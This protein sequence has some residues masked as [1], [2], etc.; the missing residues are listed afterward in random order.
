M[1][2]DRWCHYIKCGMVCLV[3]V[4]SATHLRLRLTLANWRKREG[5]VQHVTVWM[6]VGPTE[7]KQEA[8]RKRN[9]DR[10]CGC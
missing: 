2:C 1:Q 8:D 4:I 7:E 9:A 3:G 5:M 6:P 10:S